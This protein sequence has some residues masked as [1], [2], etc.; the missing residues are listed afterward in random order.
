[1]CSKHVQ[2][3]QTWLHLGQLEWQ[4]PL[5]WTPTLPP[6]YILYYMHVHCVTKAK[7][8]SLTCLALPKQ[9]QCSPLNH[10]YA[11]HGC[12]ICFKQCII[13]YGSN[14]IT[15]TKLHLLQFWQCSC[16]YIWCKSACLKLRMELRQILT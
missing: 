14:T 11:L 7:L 13:L 1:M 16:T 5:W 4:L 9:L 8:W 6:I 2:I 10:N 12:L 15:T 3:C